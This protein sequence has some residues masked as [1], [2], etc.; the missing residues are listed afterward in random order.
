MDRRPFAASFRNART[1]KTLERKKKVYPRDRG[2]RSWNLVS[3][4]SLD[5]RLSKEVSL[6]SSRTTFPPSIVCPENRR[7]RV[8][9]IKKES[10]PKGSWKGERK[11]YTRTRNGP[12]AILRRVKFD[13]RVKKVFTLPNSSIATQTAFQDFHG[14]GDD[15]KAGRRKIIIRAHRSQRSRWIRANRFLLPPSV[16]FCRS[17]STDFPIRGNAVARESLSMAKQ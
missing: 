5:P 12:R 8:T 7:Y 16:T 11:V 6:V 17:Y 9:K 2:F 13:E 10:D 3:S 1:L 4:I 15:N 14:F